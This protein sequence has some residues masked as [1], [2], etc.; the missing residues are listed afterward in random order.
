MLT[1]PEI[2]ATDVQPTAVIRLTVPRS[3]IQ[4]VMGPGFQEL[5]EVLGAQ[6]IEPIGPWFTHHLRM[7][8]ELFDFELGAPIAAPLA[9]AG[10]V[11]SG[12]LPAA[13]VA[14]A[15]YSGP[16]EGLGATWMEFDAWIVAAGHTPD[17][18]LWEIYAIG[19]ETSLNPADWRTELYRPLI[20]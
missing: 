14:R 7:D 19:P 3:E 4:S 9:P 15:V 12:L 16:Y 10:R 11:Q 8:S 20:R 13:T 6:N 18:N 17:T 1:T 5:M 2:V